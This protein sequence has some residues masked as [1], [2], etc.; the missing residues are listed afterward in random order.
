MVDIKKMLI[1]NSC[2]TFKNNKTDYVAN[3][4]LECKI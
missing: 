4:V 1:E 2:A 3:V